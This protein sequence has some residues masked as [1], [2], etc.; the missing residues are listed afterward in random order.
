MMPIDRDGD[1]R[2]Q[3]SGRRWLIQRFITGD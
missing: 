2:W 3:L 1:Q